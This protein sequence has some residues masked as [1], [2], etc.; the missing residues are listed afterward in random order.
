MLDILNKLKECLGEAVGLVGGYTEKIGR[1]KSVG[2][3]GEFR[4]VS[5]SI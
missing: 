5:G 1:L 3:D 2:F 4:V